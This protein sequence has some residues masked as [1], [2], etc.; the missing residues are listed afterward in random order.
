MPKR[1]IIPSSVGEKGMSVVEGY[2]FSGVNAVPYHFV[3]CIKARN[4]S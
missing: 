2:S 1:I 3:I 4:V